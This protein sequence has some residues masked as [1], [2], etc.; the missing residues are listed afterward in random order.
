MGELMMLIESDKRG[1][2]ELP[3]TYSK[4]ENE[5]F[6]VPPNL[7]L[8]GTMNTADRSLAMVDYALR[9]RFCFVDLESKYGSQ[10]FND[11]LGNMGVSPGLIRRINSNLSTLNKLI[12]EDVPT[13]GPGFRIGHS[14]FCTINSDTNPD[15]SWYQRI[16]KFE[17]A[18]LL[19]E[20]WY[21]S[22]DKADSR[23]KILND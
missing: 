4:G 1:K 10:K 7:Y 2:I 20:Y 11:Y 9:R 8:I 19:H 13:L 21:D 3:L 23:V 14:Y 17:I 12:E 16:V 6:T 22:P 15:D 18:P 5:T